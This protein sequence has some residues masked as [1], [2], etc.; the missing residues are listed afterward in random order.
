LKEGLSKIFGFNFR[1]HC[2]IFA[3]LLLTVSPILS[4]TLYMI[5][6]IR[7]AIDGRKNV[8]TTE[9]K[10]LG[11]IFCVISLWFWHQKVLPEQFG[12][13]KV[14]FTDYVPFFFFFYALSLK[15][16]LDS[17]IKAILYAFVVTIPQQFFIALGERYFNWTGRFYFPMRRLPIID[18]YFGPS[19]VGLDTS[20]SFFNP[21]IFAIYVV[22]GILFSISLWIKESEEAGSGSAEYR[23]KSGFLFFV[24]LMSV[25]LLIWTNS[26]NAWFFT[27]LAILLF[28]HFV[29]KRYFKVLGIGMLLITLLAILNLF[30]PIPLIQAILP[31]SL[32]S[33]LMVFLNDRALYYKVAWELIEKKPWTGW[34]IGMFSHLVP[35]TKLI[36]YKVLHAHS[37]PLQLAV[38]VGVP[39]AIMTL[40]AWVGLL[41]LTARRL[42]RQKVTGSR[43][44]VLSKGLLIAFATIFLMQFFDLALLMTYRLNFLFCLCLAIPYSKVSASLQGEGRSMIR[45][46]ELSEN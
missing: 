41:I 31:K 34:G 1:K 7:S 36:W 29:K 42:L 28:S 17:E 22:L 11:G 14:S 21:N 20:A 15:P 8:W 45:T 16:F 18:I 27:L 32:T 24:L 37:L 5:G 26:R 30:Y 39:F 6:A 4:G 43:S 12:P 2:L 23:V 3:T 9:R 33:K 35:H 44:D 13:G 10:I 38:E 46:K 19:E 40:G 25:L